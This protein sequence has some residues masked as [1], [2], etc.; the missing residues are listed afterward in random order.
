MVRDL[1]VSVALFCFKGEAC[2]LLKYLK[3]YVV[4]SCW[5]V[6]SDIFMELSRS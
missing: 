6:S 4:V 1:H 5:D 2:K 3:K